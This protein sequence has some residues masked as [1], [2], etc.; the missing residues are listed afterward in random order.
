MICN[1]Q[2]N[3]ISFY[4]GQII[5][6]I[7]I[8]L[9]IL[10]KQ[11]PKVLVEIGT[12]RG[13]TLFLL[14]KVAAKDAEIIS[15]DLPDGKFGGEFP[16][17]KNQIYPSFATNKQQIHIIRAASQ[18]NSTFSE[19][20]KIL[21]KNKI[22]FLFIDGDHRYNYVKKDFELYSPF[23]SDEGLIGFHDICFGPLELAG[24][25][26]RFWNEIKSNYNSVE[27]I[28]NDCTL[29]RG[30]GLIVLNKSDKPNQKFIEILE[31][32]IETKNHLSI[33]ENKSFNRKFPKRDPRI[34][35]HQY[36]NQI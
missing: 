13:G 12:G 23:M 28:D 19:L 15:I 5:N 29:G 17:W 32:I 4:P 21:G 36:L 22:D 24:E 35:I 26:A 31:S 14:S 34:P 18:D 27:I 30:I 3:E 10:S 11:L 20:E 25:V 33:K 8:L 1:F 7:Y 6:E 9:M 16:L 2:Y